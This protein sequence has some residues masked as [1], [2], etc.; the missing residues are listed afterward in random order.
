MKDI[1]KYVF[2]SCLCLT[3]L[4]IIFFC[5]TTT[6]SVFIEKGMVV[7]TFIMVLNFILI[8]VLAFIAYVFSK[9]EM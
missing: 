6:I 7:G 8:S 1:F 5:V 9:M 3:A 4:S 2:I